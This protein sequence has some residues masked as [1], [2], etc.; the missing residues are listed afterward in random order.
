[1]TRLFK[2]IVVAVDGSKPSN[3]ALTVACDLAKQVGATVHVRH[4]LAMHPELN[5]RHVTWLPE[6]EAEKRRDAGAIVRAAETLVKRRG[7]DAEVGVLD[8]DPIDELLRA[9][10]EL[11]ADTIVI[12]NRGQSAISSL[13]MGSVGQGVMERSKVPV[14]VVHESPLGHDAKKRAV[15]SAAAAR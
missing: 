13:L 10:D 4:V 6:V 14:L 15:S 7:V 5:G 2:N 8:G 11:G 9:A 1:M 3:A 12:G